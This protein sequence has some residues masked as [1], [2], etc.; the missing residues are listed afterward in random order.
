MISWGPDLVCFFKKGQTLIRHGARVVLSGTCWLYIR[1]CLPSKNGKKKKKNK[2]KRIFAPLSFSWS[3]S[4]SRVLRQELPNAKK[5]LK[6]PQTMHLE[7][8]GSRETTT[9]RQS[10]RTKNIKNNNKNIK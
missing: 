7:R 5:S 2:K 8:V 9:E 6:K 10:K 4:A 1:L 3:P